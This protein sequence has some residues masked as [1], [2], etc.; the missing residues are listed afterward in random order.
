MPVADIIR[1]S[2]LSAQLGQYGEISEADF[3]KILQDQVNA[4]CGGPNASWGQGCSDAQAEVDSAVNIFATVPIGSG[5]YTGAGIVPGPSGIVSYNPSAGYVV[6]PGSL[7]PEQSPT[8][9]AYTSPS[10]VAL[11]SPGNP[12]A[13]GGGSSVAGTAAG[14]GPS[15]GGSNTLQSPYDPGPTA[16]PGL[17]SLSQASQ[18]TKILAILLIIAVAVIFFGRH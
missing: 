16:G 14:A 18:N 5:F 11:T 13:S 17:A 12:L 10:N 8:I 2:V 4:E 7:P 9:P 6:P 3:R 1:E 15:S